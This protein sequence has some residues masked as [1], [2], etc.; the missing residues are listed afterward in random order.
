MHDLVIKNARIIDGLGNLA[1][2]GELAV[3]DGR[4]SEIGP[5]IGDGREVMDAEGLS[6]SP[7]IIDPNLL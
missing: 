2:N 4:I 1:T 6:L 3:K 7:G 5:A